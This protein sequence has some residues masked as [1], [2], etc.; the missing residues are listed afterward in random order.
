MRLA[1][2]QGLQQ[3]RPSLAQ[4]MVS[5]PN[6]SGLAMDQ[7]T[8]LYSPTYYVRSVKVSYRGEPVLSSDVDFSI[9]EKPNFRFYVMT[10][11]E[12]SL[13]VTVSDTQDKVLKGALVLATLG[14]NAA[15]P[16]G[17]SVRRE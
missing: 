4:L 12:G 17:T 15:K 7:L 5:H 6:E 16:R 10:H 9:S 3:G 1:L 14:Q 11:G 2:P 13:E 8:R